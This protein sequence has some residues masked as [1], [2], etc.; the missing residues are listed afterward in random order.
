M[1]WALVPTTSLGYVA[2][3]LFSNIVACLSI[4][5]M[6]AR[7]LIGLAGFFISDSGVLPFLQSEQ[8]CSLPSGDRANL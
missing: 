5:F 1:A 7:F 4:G 8:V 2:L 6:A 3:G